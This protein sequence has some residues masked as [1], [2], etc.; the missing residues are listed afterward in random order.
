MFDWFYSLLYCWQFW[1]VYIVLNCGPTWYLVYK[2]QRWVRPVKASDPKYKP[3]HSVD[4]PKAFTYITATVLGFLTIPRFIIGWTIFLFTPLIAK[5]LSM[6]LKEGDKI[7]DW[8]KK[9]I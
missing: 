2:K 7:P 8:R 6:D 3:F 4:D 1:V 5:I 9:F